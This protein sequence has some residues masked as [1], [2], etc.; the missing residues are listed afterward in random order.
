MGVAVFDGCDIAVITH[1]TKTLP[2]LG[3]S[4]VLAYPG[5]PNTDLLSKVVDNLRNFTGLNKIS[6]V[7]DHKVDCDIS[8]AYL[9]N[10]RL[11]CQEQQLRLLVSPS[12]LA[13]PSQ[14]TATHAFHLASC[15]S[16][17]PYLLLWE[18]DHLFH[19]VI[20]WHRIQQAMDHGA[21]MIRFNRRPNHSVVGSVPEMVEACEFSEDLCR[22]DYYCN[23][24]FIARRSWLK[25]LFDLALREPPS[26]N[27]C[28]GGFVEG[29]INRTM[30]ADRYNK[31]E[32]EYRHLYPIYLYG[33]LN[34][35]PIVSHFGEFLGR[36]G[37]WL[38][39]L[40]RAGLWR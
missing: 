24:P 16:E 10:L 40:R 9:A 1:A 11:F 36:R 20:D 14:Q 5:A 15:A 2:E 3:R 25:P 29:P 19:E 33:G 32:E 37:R 34:A 27:G 28:F 18:H 6:I 31:S 7:F 12:A 39:A 8:C 23:G 26:W 13:M 4:D 35:Q 30:L 38:A 21:A 17:S 22:T